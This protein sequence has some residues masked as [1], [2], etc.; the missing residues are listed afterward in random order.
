M[1]TTTSRRRRGLVALALGAALLLTG[2]TED[3]KDPDRGSTG[4]SSSQAPA[5]ETLRDAADSVLRFAAADPVVSQSGT[6]QG[7]DG[8]SA[9]VEVASLAR[10]AQSTV[11]LLK[12]T[13]AD[14]VSPR[15][16][17]SRDEVGDEVDG[18]ALSVGT[19]KFYP[20]RYLH[21]EA[22]LAKECICTEVIRRLGPE[23]VWVSAE[24]EPLP[25]DAATATLEI[26][27]FAPFEVPV[28]A[29]S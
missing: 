13:T 4:S 3:T 5:G 22:A 23:G 28:T 8:S 15:G 11:L 17:M 26:P 27:G 10:G 21:G 2:C 25:A 20:A 24:F 7:K 9:K 18:I 29:R 12:I 1:T 14:K 19:T 16:A 6:L